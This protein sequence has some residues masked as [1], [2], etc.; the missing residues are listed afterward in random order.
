VPLSAVVS[1]PARPDQYGVF[2]AQEQPG[3]WVANLRQV[4]LGET[5]ESLVAVNGVKPG[6]KVVVV[7]AAQ[8]KDGDSIQVIP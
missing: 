1:D 7:G 8:L 6:E 3:R 5:Q 4:T 2:V